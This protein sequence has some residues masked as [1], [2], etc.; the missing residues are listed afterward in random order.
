MLHAVGRGT[1]WVI[2]PLER[3]EVGK[4]SGRILE[5]EEQMFMVNQL[6]PFPFF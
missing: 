5:R 4:V 3:A 6:K 1:A 2:G